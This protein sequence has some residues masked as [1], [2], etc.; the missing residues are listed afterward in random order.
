MIERVF[1]KPFEEVFEQFDEQ[2]IGCGAIAQVYKGT[3]RP[4]I[5]PPSYHERKKRQ[6]SPSSPTSVI[7]HPPTVGTDIVSVPH[8]SVAIKILHPK[9]HQT[10]ARDLRIMGFF[11]SILNA[12]PGMEWL[13]FPDEVKVFGEMMNQQLDLTVEANNLSG[14]EENFLMRRNAVSFPRPVR[15][16]STRDVLVE[17]FE[18][19]LPLKYFLRNGGGQYDDQLA[20]MGLDAFLVRLA[21]SIFTIA[22]EL[23]S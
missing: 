1:Q 13:S 14:F 15:D 12:F 6:P 23:R 2:P 7:T 11:A 16:F 19:A 8:S 22:H 10:I 3:L 21:Q 20:N 9:V 18:N 4:E 5:L 17:E